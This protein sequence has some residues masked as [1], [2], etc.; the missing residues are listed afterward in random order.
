MLSRMRSRAGSVFALA[1]LAAACGDSTPFSSSDSD[2]GTGS[3]DANAADAGNDGATSHPLDAATD[4]DGAP[5]IDACAKL[6]DVKYCKVASGG[7]G[8]QTCVERPDHTLAYGPCI[9]V[10]CDASAKPSTNE[11]C[12][13]AGDFTM[14]GLDGSGGTT[15]EN[16]TLP[17]HKATMRHR[18]YVDKFEVTMREWNAWWNATPRSVPADNALVYVS[19]NG[20]VVRWTMPAAGLQPAGSD[21]VGSFCVLGYGNDPAKQDVSINCVPYDSALAYC[22]VAGKRLPTEAEWEY[23]AAGQSTGDNYPWGNTAPDASCTQSIDAPCVTATSTAYPSIRPAAA[24][25][26]TPATLGAVNN[27]AGN[28]AEWTLDFCPPAGCSLNNTCF[29]TG[30]LDPLAITDNGLGKIVRGGSFQSDADHVRTRA[31][32]HLKPD[33]A[34]TVSAVGFRCVRDER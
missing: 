27:L 2:S 31:R 24:L 13:P 32:D 26:D 25:G 22:L 28:E 18:F 19:G 7:D 17:A 33:A 29:P 23:V 12:I 10:A 20:D 4:A 3:P 16:D 9:A 34:T 11:A 15:P 8:V 1:A 14:G 30:A 21:L 5:P 6:G